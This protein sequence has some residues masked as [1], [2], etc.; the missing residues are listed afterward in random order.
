[1]RQ[2]GIRTAVSALTAMVFFEYDESTI[3]SEAERILRDKVTVM[4][5][6]PQVRL[7]VEGH[8]DERGSTEY[9]IALGQRRADAIVQFMTGF[10]IDASRLSTT[11]YGEERPMERGETESAWSR[12]RRGEFAITAGEASIQP[13]TGQ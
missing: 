13:W 6:N 10:G 1:M 4:R 8:A 9:N 11:S 7:R 3:T 12:N 5:A 2:E